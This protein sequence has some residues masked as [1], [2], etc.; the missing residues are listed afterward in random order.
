MAA[1]TY[2]PENTYHPHLQQFEFP[3]SAANA[4]FVYNPADYMATVP[5]D[6][7][8][9]MTGPGPA[10]AG[11]SEVI[12]PEPSQ[13]PALVYPTASLP[14]VS[15]VSAQPTQVI[16]SSLTQSNVRYLA[17]T[18]PNHMT[19]APTLHQVMY[20]AV[21]PTA[22][23][24]GISGSNLPLQVHYNNTQ[25]NSCVNF[26]VCFSFSINSVL[27]LVKS[28]LKYSCYMLLSPT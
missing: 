8:P 26:L 14:A 23:I 4:Q 9:V 22:M 17:V 20:P 6:V 21:T 10:A 18:Q 1:S 2:T 24:Y 11:A 16:Y 28:L 13:E 25:N 5:A 15:F 19:Y 7:A 3:A 12:P 27:V